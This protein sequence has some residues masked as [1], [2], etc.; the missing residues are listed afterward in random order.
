MNY[1]MIEK[2]SRTADRN[3][4]S[5]ANSALFGLPFS[6]ITIFNLLLSLLEIA[7]QYVT[8][9][10]PLFNRIIQRNMCMR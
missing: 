9:Q 8:E 4:V 7:L 5:V 1:V 10:S 3:L 6:Y 2:L